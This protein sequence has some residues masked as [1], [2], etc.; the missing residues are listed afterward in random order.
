MAI[1]VKLSRT[2]KI[3][4]R[5]QIVV[6]D[7][8]SVLNDVDVSNVQDGYVL[9]YDNALQEYTFVDPDVLLSKAVADNNLPQDFLNKLDVD[10]DDRINVDAG[11]F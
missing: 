1:Q 7:N 8:I 6:P 10:L 9:M 11:Q 4:V 2:P 5:T 3:K